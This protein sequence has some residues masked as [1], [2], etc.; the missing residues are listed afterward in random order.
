MHVCPKYLTS[1]EARPSRPWSVRG[2]STAPAVSCSMARVSSWVALL[3]SEGHG[4]RA[5]L[6]HRWRGKIREL[7]AYSTRRSEKSEMQN[8]EEKL[9]GEHLQNVD[10][11]Y[12]NT[13]DGYRHRPPFAG[14]STMQVP[15]WSLT[16]N[17]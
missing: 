3:I 17:L 12:Y 5:G 4:A 13:R 9:R 16:C 2:N 8:P 6:V 7:I 11:M 10:I 14:L 15:R 1:L